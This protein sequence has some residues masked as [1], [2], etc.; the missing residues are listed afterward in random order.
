MA[1]RQ[2]VT[3]NTGGNIYFKKS[4]FGA[5]STDFSKM[6]L[7]PVFFGRSFQS[8]FLVLYSRFDLVLCLAVFGLNALF[9]N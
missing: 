4:N 5:T 7:K 2:C 6:R 3:G 8:R 1:G 9:V